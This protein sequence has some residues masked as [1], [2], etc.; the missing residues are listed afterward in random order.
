MENATKALLIAGAVLVVI[1][2][3]AVGLKILN[4]TSGTADQVKSQS[5]VMEIQIFNSQFTKYLG[6]Q[7]ASEVKALL[8]LI[9]TTEREGSEHKVTAT[10]ITSISDVKVNTQYTVS[11]TNYDKDGYIT[12][13]SIAEKK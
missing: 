1:V 9:K 2:L 4:A 8:S 3:I 7:P 6:T 13:I 5:E 10:G 12:T 11:D